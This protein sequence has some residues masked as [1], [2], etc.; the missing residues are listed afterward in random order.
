MNPDL[1]LTLQRVIRAP[2]TTV[3]HAW[4]DPAQLARW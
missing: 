4:T 3:W 1:D 2:R